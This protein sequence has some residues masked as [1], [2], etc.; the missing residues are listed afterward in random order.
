MFPREE[1][2]QARGLAGRRWRWTLGLVSTTQRGWDESQTPAPCNSP[3][4]CHW[5]QRQ[6]GQA[7][8][9]H[10]QAHLPL[11]HPFQPLP[12]GLV[13]GVHKNCQGTPLGKFKARPCFPRVGGGPVS[14]TS[15]C[16]D[17]RGTQMYFL[18]VLKLE[19]HPRC[20]GYPSLEASLPS[21]QTA[22]FLVSSHGL[23]LWAHTW[24]CKWRGI[25]LVSLPLFIRTPVLSG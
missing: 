24:G 5:G 7:P 15:S 23:F 13:P 11:S 9:R 16:Q 1:E 22:T 18:T 10:A 14:V 17:R 3:R 12:E 8:R 19:V 6:A 25:H 21:L 2:T 20:Q 4:F